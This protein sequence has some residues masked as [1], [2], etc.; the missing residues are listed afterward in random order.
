MSMG[1]ER[2]QWSYRLESVRGPPVRGDSGP[3][4]GE[5]D[6]DAGARRCGLGARADRPAG[7]VGPELGRVV[8][9]KRPPPPDPFDQ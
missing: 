1:A 9:F 8:I 5:D 3:F 4:P 7:G 6:D 2:Q